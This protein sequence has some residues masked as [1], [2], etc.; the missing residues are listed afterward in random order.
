VTLADVRAC[1][2]DNADSSMDD[3]VDATTGGDLPALDLALARARSADLSP[4][5]LLN[6]L[7]RHLVQLHLALG[8]METGTPTDVAMR[9]I[10][11]PVH[12]SRTAAVRRQIGLWNRRRLDRALSLVA[13]ADTQCKTTGLPENAICG[14]TLLRIA[15]AARAGAR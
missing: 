3:V 7:S 9:A 14:Q 5:A 6:A 2:G 4:I 8:E 15:Q 13:E 10:R 1:I 11:P 12:F